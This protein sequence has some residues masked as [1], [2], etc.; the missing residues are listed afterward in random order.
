MTGM[1]WP[2]ECE[3]AGHVGP[4]G[5][6][7][8]TRR[9]LVLSALAHFCPPQDPNL[10]VVH[11]YSGSSCLNLETPSRARPGVFLLVSLDPVTV[12]TLA[13]PSSFRTSEEEAVLLM[14]TLQYGPAPEQPRDGDVRT[15]SLWTSFQRLGGHSG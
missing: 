6:Q 11:V 15:P 8:K 4:I 13:V 1:S 2:Q 5:K 12:A 3:A 9:E 10:C 14:I 7:G